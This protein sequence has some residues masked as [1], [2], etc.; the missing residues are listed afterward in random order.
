MSTESMTIDELHA[1]LLSSDCPTCGNGKFVQEMYKGTD[2]IVCGEC[3]TPR[4]RVW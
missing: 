3:G 4:I 1:A 2:A